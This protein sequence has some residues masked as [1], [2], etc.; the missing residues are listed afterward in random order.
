MIIHA[1]R[2]VFAT[3]KR[4]LG[5][6]VFD[7]AASLAYYTLLSLFPLMLVVLAV[8][9]QVLSEE[10]QQGLIE[11]LADALPTSRDLIVDNVQNV[12]R[13]RGPVG[14]VG[15]IFLVWAGSNVFAA[16]ERMLNRVWHVERQRA[17]VAVQLRRLGMGLLTTPVLL[18]SFGASVAIQAAADVF[19]NAVAIFLSTFA[20]VLVSIGVFTLIYR[21]G[22]NTRVTWNA[23]LIGG[24]TGGIGFEVGKLAFAVYAAN[25]SNFALVYGALAGTIAFLIWIYWSCVFLLIGAEVAAVAG[26]DAADYE[27]FIQ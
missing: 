22:P 6:H 15:A 3:V 23:A 2:F 26:R 9:G 14:A 4:S 11:R 17:F 13:L 12:A 18:V 7:L 10:A 24:V 1:Y 16:A 27:D 21:L 8:I 5:D 20:I 25:F 19:V